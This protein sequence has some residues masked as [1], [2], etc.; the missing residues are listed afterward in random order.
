MPKGGAWER[1]FQQLKANE[2]ELNRI[3]IDLYGLQE[4]LTPEVPEAEVTVR[5]A[6]RER[7]V[8]S[9]LSYCVGLIMGRYSLDVG[10]LAYAGGEWEASKY[11][12]L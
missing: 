9:F 4:E 2:E 5:R 11:Q 10:G 7:D 3:F 6:E 8:K 12:T 1:Q